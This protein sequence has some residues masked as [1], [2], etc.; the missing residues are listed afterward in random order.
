M[1]KFNILLRDDRSQIYIRINMKDDWPYVGFTRNPADDGAE[2]YGP[3]YNSY[4]IR[5]AI[6]Y[7]RRSFPFY[8]RPHSGDDRLSLN[9]Q[10][11]LE[12][13]GLTSGEYH[14]DLRKLISYIKGDRQKI[15]NELK[16]DM[17]LAARE[18][19]FE[20]AA[21]YRNRLFNLNE[22]KK[23]IMFGDEE[24][25]DISKDQ[26]LSDLTDLLGLKTEPR[27]IE[28]YDVSH[29]SGTNVVASMVVFTNGVSDRSQYRKFKTKIEQNNDFFNM[30][31]IIKRRFTDEN[32]TKWG[33][34]DLCLI[35]GGKG[36]L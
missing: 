30:A 31:E 10:I 25:L 23:R 1:P 22:L 27:R 11:G 2:Y 36:Q 20:D 5:K 12:P 7:L 17:E 6:R 21:V 9:A 32:I 3:Y 13:A 29:M 34:P 19:R 15:I 4:A 24:Y 26:A 8:D 14:Q 16:H 28:G 18:H 33:K 35:D